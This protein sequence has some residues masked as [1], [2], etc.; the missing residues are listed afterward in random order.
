MEKINPVIAKLIECISLQTPQPPGNVEPVAA[1]IEAWVKSFGAKVE[2]QTVEPGKD[3]IIA[4]L[5]FGP[6]PSLLFNSHMDVNNP[7]GQVW[8]NPPFE[9]K[10]ADGRLYGL[11]ACDAKGSL[12]AMITAMEHLA[13]NKNGLQ[14][15][16]ILAA[17][18]GEEAGGIG[19]LH[20]VEQGIEADGAVVG[21]PT[22][23]GVC[24]AH[25][26]TYMRR[27]RFRGRAAHSGSP[28]LGVN[29]ILHTAYFT[30]EYEKLK[31]QLVKCPHPLLG[32]P[33]A[34]VTIIQGGTRQNTIPGNTE[35]II[36]RRLLPGETH[37]KADEELEM[38]LAN[39][40]DK[41][42][43]LHVEEIEVVVATV[44][45]ET[46]Q[47]EAIVKEAL[48]AVKNVTG[49]AQ[50]P[51]G[52]PAGCDMSKLVTIA[53][54]PTVVVGPGSLDQAHVPDEFVEITQVEQAV[55][56]YEQ[57]ARKFLRR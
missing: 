22:Q 12:V 31:N 14:G 16:M 17:V 4:T 49:N 43:S 1:W 57:I 48:A 36:D 24:T 5:D 8:S 42:S 50:Q 30:V 15:K 20:L 39:T 46:N 33:S 13:R 32:P 34:E 2:R 25:K 52:F 56:I 47:S 7:T 18:M 44:P 38:V 6:G 53:G 35:I 3:N 11:G 45:S 28:H 37:A 9:P 21:E 26:G 51:K 10:I 54:I 27:L 19:S 23:L 40:K 55:V 29:S 41:V